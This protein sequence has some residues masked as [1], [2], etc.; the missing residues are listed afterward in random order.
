V[1]PGALPVRVA[2]IVMAA[3]FLA[4]PR[5]ASAI[6]AFARAT[7]LPCSGCHTAW[8]KLNRFGRAY[9][10]NGYA[11]ERG[12]A[13]G[14]LEI[15]DK[16]S[17]PAHAPLSIVVNSRP[18]D[19]KKRGTTKLRALHELEILAGGSMFNY[20]SFF[21]EL[22]ME[23]ENNFDP[24]LGHAWVGVHPYS[25]FN[26]IAGY[27]PVFAGD[28]YNTLRDRKLTRARP[29]SL[30]EGFGGSVKLKSNAQMFSVYGRVPNFEQVFGLF[31]YATDRNN[32]FEGEGSTDYTG[33]IAFDIT[34]WAM[35]GGFG[36]AGK[37]N[38]LKF[39]RAGGDLQLQLEPWV[40]LEAVGYSAFDERADGDNADP[41][42]FVVSTEIY[43][44]LGE[45]VFGT[46]W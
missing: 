8:P 42:N 43:P 36:I 44:F 27:A 24:E 33:R 45:E 21:G 17:I 4:A 46:I 10:E 15:G 22:E 18:Y 1:G 40:N 6:P 37:E 38:D 9:K 31:T 2:M 16:L 34:D 30:D 32:D 28:P 20:G 35:I 12:N 11:I 25:F 7:E 5:D 41:D 29:I 3:A 39:H 23:D 19:R 26:V 13:E 14:Q